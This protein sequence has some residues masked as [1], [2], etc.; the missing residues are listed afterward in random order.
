MSVP[1]EVIRRDYSGAELRALSSRCSDG[2]QVRRL[3]AIAMV[4]EGRSRSEAAELNGMDRQTLRDWVHRYN[5]AGV[6]GLKSLASPGRARSLSEQQQAELLDLVLAGPDPQVHGVVRWR[7]VDL[8]AEVERRFSV[9]VHVN[10]IGRWLHE[11]GLTRL[12]PRPQHP[13]KDPQAE[14]AFKKTSPVWSMRRSP[15][16]PS[17]DPWRS[18]SRT[19]LA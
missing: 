8:Q 1:V 13:Q 5:A 14:E 16:A 6:E 12:Q 3:L 9:K 7:C 11:L 4:L 19:R 2:A 18:G 10:T 15:R 17:A